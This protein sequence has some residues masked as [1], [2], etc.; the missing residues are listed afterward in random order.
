VWS[1]PWLKSLK[2]TEF[3]C[4][5]KTDRVNHVRSVAELDFGGHTPV[6]VAG[7]QVK[8]AVEFVIKYLN[9]QSDDFYTLE[10]FQVVNGTQQV[11]VIDTMICTVAQLT[12]I[13]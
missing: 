4:D 10:L 5:E 13:C 1:Q 6:D 3:H 9:S 7:Y 11:S 12:V 2:L 8:H